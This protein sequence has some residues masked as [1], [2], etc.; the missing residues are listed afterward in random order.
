MAKQS[1][2]NPF[3]VVL[4]LV[5]VAFLLTAFLYGLLAFREARGYPTAESGAGLL[6]AMDRYGVWLLVGELALLI[7]S[8]IAAMATDSFWTRK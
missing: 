7:I 1:R 8:S 4:V 2:K 6:A 3:Y 5:G